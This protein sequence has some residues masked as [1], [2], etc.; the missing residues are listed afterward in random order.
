M[1]RPQI[2]KFPAWVERASSYPALTLQTIFLKIYL[3]TFF[4]HFYASH[5]RVQIEWVSKHGSQALSTFLAQEGWDVL[6]NVFSASKWYLLYKVGAL[7]W[8]TNENIVTRVL[9]DARPVPRVYR[10]WLLWTTTCWMP[11]YNS[12]CN[13]DLFCSKVYVLFMIISAKN[14][15]HMVKEENLRCPLTYTQAHILSE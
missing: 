13:S 1:Q 6:G 15:T 4:L 9:Q 12:H 2:H 8:S 3:G 5:L 14:L 11:R 10:T 7:Y